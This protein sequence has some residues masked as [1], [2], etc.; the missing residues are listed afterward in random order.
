MVAS[1]IK[2]SSAGCETCA[3]VPIRPCEQEHLFLR[4]GVDRPGSMLKDIA[5]AME[6]NI[7]GAEGKGQ[8]LA[9][10]YVF[11]FILFGSSHGLV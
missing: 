3:H 7:S 5:G 11:T 9:L 1:V 2:T 8:R 10:L 6:L 4:V